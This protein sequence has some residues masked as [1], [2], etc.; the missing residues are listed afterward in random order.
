M[1]NT[2]V[3][4]TL[5]LYEITYPVTMSTMTEGY[6]KP[7]ERLRHGAENKLRWEAKQP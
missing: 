5:K 4:I 6:C 2:E 1:L 7:K 3:S